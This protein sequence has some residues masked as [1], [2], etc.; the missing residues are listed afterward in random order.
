M[1]LP[2][3]ALIFLIFLFFDASSQ[4]KNFDLKQSIEKVLRNHKTILASK[5]DI[6]AAKT[7]LEPPS[8]IPSLRCFK[9]PTPPDAITGIFKAL[10]IF[11]VNSLLCYFVELASLSVAFTVI[12]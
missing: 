4:N 2:K 5:T 1:I 8:T 10:D 3:V 7:A 9:D 6:E 12:A 11:L